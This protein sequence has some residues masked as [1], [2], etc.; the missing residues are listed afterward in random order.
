MAMRKIGLVG[1]ISWTSTLDYYRYINEG[2]NAELGGLNFAECVID[3]VNFD[4]F[5]RYNA[6]Y[7]W[8]AT[9]VLLA[10]AANN[11]KK[12]GATAILLCANT[13]HI[14]ADRIEAAVQLPVLHITTATAAAIQQQQL[15]KVGLLGTCYTMELDFYKDKLKAAGIE[16]I[17]PKN[18]ADRDYIEDTLLHELGKGIIQADTKQKYLAIIQQLIDRGAEGIIL[19]CTEIPLLIQQADVAVPVFD[20]TRIHAAAAVAYAVAAPSLT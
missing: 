8:D 11:L 7:D 20:T 1:G 3:S 2:V 13:A 6:A 4:D 15:K 10:D 16:P 17:I 19:G 12:A 5:R 18:Q 14:V 9:F